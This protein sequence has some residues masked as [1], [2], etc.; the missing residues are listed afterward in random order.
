MIGDEI[1]NFC[2]KL[3]PINRSITGDGVRE[4]LGHIQGLIPQLEIKEITSGTNVFDWTIPREWNVNDAWIKA[5]CGKKICEFKKNNLHLVGYSLPIHTMMPLSELEPHLFSLE[6]QPSAIPYV[7]SYYNDYWG[8]CLT[9]EQRQSLT[10]GDYE[11]F[12][13]ASLSPGALTYGEVIMEGELSDEVFLSSY[14]CHPSMANNELSG[15]SVLT[16]VTDQ[17]SKMIDRKYTYRIAFVPETIGSIAYLS[18]NIDAMKA[19]I[20]AG[21]NL[22]CI[23]DNR[24]YSYLPS[25]HGDTYSDKIVQ[26]VLHSIK[27]D[28]KKYSW[29]DR[30]S[31][32]RQYC[33]PGIDLPVASIMRTK[34]GVYPEYH[35]SLDN[36][37]KVVTPKGLE[38]GFNAVMRSIELIEKNCNPKVKILGE[39]QMGKRNLYPLISN[40]QRNDAI[41]AMM[42]IIS[43]SDGNN[44]LINIAEQCQIPVWEVYA[45]IDSLESHNII[46][47]EPID[48]K[49]C[50]PLIHSKHYT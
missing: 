27:P 50:P 33:A 17:I 36:L 38:G 42:N 16:Y 37:E 3:W 34:Y 2:A 47:K 40:N 4:T 15:I 22:T 29:N 14:I 26:H 32:E 6:K 12:I 30:G 21:F 43:Y 24:D 7:T 28:F 19:N 25:R 5:P 39:P 10:E 49:H 8:F 1:H 11:V 31:D 13:D 46:S 41:K 48:P 45:V 35:T 23:G 44:D 20:I 18:Q 9:H